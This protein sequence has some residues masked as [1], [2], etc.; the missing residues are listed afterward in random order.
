MVTQT[1]F[2]L[3][4]IT[5]AIQRLFELFK[6]RRQVNALVA[7]GGREHASG[8]YVFM[9]LVHA[10]WFASMLAE[11][12]LLK[13]PF[14]W[15]LC[16]VALI[17]T[18]CGNTLRYLSMKALG[19]RWT[20]RIVTLPGEKPVVTGIYQYLRHPI[21]LGVVLELA[22]IP[23]LHSAYLTALL[24]AVLNAL[25]LRIRI[26]EEEKALRHEGGYDEAFGI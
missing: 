13:R 21:Y 22:G 9:V 12:F 11:V 16:A 1:L 23:L 26:R 15:P 3:V 10:L 24:F 2:V 19:D 17:L 25:V 6:S 4:V 14:V 7:R 5:V 8:H 20:T 18:L